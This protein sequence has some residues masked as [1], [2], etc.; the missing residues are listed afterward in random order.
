MAKLQE[1]SGTHASS[2]GHI[3]RRSRT[4]SILALFDFILIHYHDIMSELITYKKRNFSCNYV[5]MSLSLSQNNAIA[6]CNNMKLSHNSVILSPFLVLQQYNSAHSHWRPSQKKQTTTAVLFNMSL[7]HCPRKPNVSRIFLA[8]G[9][10]GISL[11]L[12]SRWAV[13]G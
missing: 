12:C 13:A 1:L 10:R 2:V 9:K 5:I 11:I 6:S 4:V 7:S 8:S 3:K